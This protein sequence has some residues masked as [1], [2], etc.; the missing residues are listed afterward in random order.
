LLT[1]GN[2]F[3]GVK[4]YAQQKYAFS[5][6]F[7]QTPLLEAFQILEK[8]HG[9]RFSF[10]NSAVAGIKTTAKVQGK[11]LDLAMQALFE[12]TQLDFYITGENQVL[13]RRKMDRP[14]SEGGIDT[15]PRPRSITGVLLDGL[16]REPLAFG[17]V[18]SG[19]GEITV[20]DE[21]GRFQLEL[22]NGNAKTEIAAQFLGYQTRKWWVE[23]G[24]EPLEMT[25]RLT[26]KI[27]ELQGVTIAQRLPTLSRGANEQISA[28]NLKALDRLP[29]FLGQ[30][31]VLR[32]L[33]YLPGVSAV[34][35]FSANPGIRGGTGDENLVLLDGITLY[36][37]S[38]YFGIFSLVNP[39]VVDKVT[40]YKNAFPVEYGGRTSA[41]IDIRSKNLLNEERKSQ[42]IFD[43]NVLTSSGLLDAPVGKKLR[44]MAAGRVTNQNLAGSDLFNLL[45]QQT[46]N[47]PV[48]GDNNNNAKVIREV[49]SQSPAVHFFDLNTKLYWQPSDKFSAQLSAFRGDDTYDYTQNRSVTQIQRNRRELVKDTFAESADWQNQGLSLILEPI[50]SKNWSSNIVLAYSAYDLERGITQ[51]TRITTPQFQRPLFSLDNTH[52]NEIQGLDFN[53]KNTWTW[54]KAQSL[55]FG[56]QLTG[57]R[58]QV[59][60]NSERGLHLDRDDQAAQHTIYAGYRGKTLDEKLHINGGLRGSLFNQKIY[61]SPRVELSWGLSPQFKPK[62]SW[63]IYQQFV[64]QLY[65]EDR[66]GR[67]YPYWV[68]AGDDLPVQE[69]HNLMLGFDHKNTWFDLNVEFYH[70]DIIGVLEYARQQ[71]SLTF[72]REEVLRDNF[73]FFQGNGKVIGLDLLF[74]KTIGAYSGWLSYTLSKSTQQFPRVANNNPFPAPNDRR[75]QLKWVNQ[76]QWK[77]FDFAL[78]YNY[79]TGRP[80]TDLSK[81]EG[82][83]PNRDNLN[84]TDRIS[85]LE[86]YIR[87][88]FSATYSFQLK[89]AKMQANVTLFNLFDRNNVKYRQYIYSYQPADPRQGTRALNTV[90]GLEF[91]MLDFTPTFGLTLQ[92]P[93]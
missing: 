44:L 78:T 16:T 28:L 58:V 4:L 49:V 73:L 71:V 83:M 39:N 67:T 40:L 84:S 80:Y 79:A 74:S 34:D 88:D 5:E 41:V 56:Y 31:D 70:R 19:Q 13:V 1:L 30:K 24:N 64:T 15:P 36:N 50:W 21:Q 82:Q 23:P 35:D 60:L 47:S 37:V 17:H 42:G 92:F 18:L 32:S 68:M 90:Q 86:A 7:H 55:D 59:E 81:L 54:G 3:F 57:N 8:K 11:D 89:G 38:H 91:Q 6:R 51:N 48:S 2:T 61:Y 46:Q 33:Q 53:W 87:T 10:E 14:L 43:F 69:S 85:Y 77:N 75:H 25:L 45:S 72:N 52:R 93:R 65:H 76:Y 26:P 27:E 66:Y 20:S 62:A 29:S 9:L 22:P 63:S 12:G